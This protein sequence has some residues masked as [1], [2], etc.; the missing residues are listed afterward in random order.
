MSINRAMAGLSLARL[1]LA[2][3]L[4]FA[5]G[6]Q[7]EVP[8]KDSSMQE[9]AENAVMQ[10]VKDVNMRQDPIPPKLLAIQH[11]PYDLENM[12]GCRALGFEIGQLDAVLGPDINQLDDVSD[13]E[14]RE[15]GASRIAGSIIG[16]LI[17]FRGIVR[18]ISG[19]NAAE[20]RFLSAIAA[21]NARRSF[22]KGVAVTKGCFPHRRPDHFALTY[23]LRGF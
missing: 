2:M 8:N 11:H 5:V 15:E 23:D 22:L 17:P 18:E 9:H 16:G 21:G 6:A 13:A 20:R 10:P 1:S 14:K 7:A 19:A 4:S 3:T 12:R